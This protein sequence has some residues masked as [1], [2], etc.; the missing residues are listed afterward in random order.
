VLCAGAAGGHT[1]V[2]RTTRTRIKE[3]RRVAVIAP[4]S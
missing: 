1:S 3:F 4:P 2:V